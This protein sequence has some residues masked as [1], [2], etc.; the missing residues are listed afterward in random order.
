MFEFTLTFNDAN[1]KLNDNPEAVAWLKECEERVRAEL[2]ECEDGVREAL[3][4][5]S[6]AST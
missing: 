3:K 1:T 2:Q 4:E 5:I 6:H